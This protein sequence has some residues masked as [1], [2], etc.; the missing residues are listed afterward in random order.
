MT[1]LLGFALI[2]ER[3]RV[4]NPLLDLLPS[5]T[6]VVPAFNERPVIARTIDSLLASDVPI[7]VVIVDDGSTDGTAEAVQR[8]YRQDARVTLLRQT[9]AGKAAALCTGFFACRTEVVVALDGDTLFAPDTVRRLLEPMRDA[10]VA[11]VAGTA[12]VGNLENALTACQALEYFTQQELERRAWGLFSALPIVPG[13]VGAWRRHAVLDVG[14]F[15]SQTL[16]EDADLAMTLCRAGWRIAYSPLAHAHTEAPITLRALIQQRVRW[17]FGVLQAMWKHR[18]APFER[19]SGAFGRLVWP[20]MVLFQIVMPLLTPAALLSVTIAALTKNWQP[21]LCTAAV[22]LTVDYL[23]FSVAALLHRRA[24]GSG[25]W[26]FAGWV[27]G[28][29]LIYRPILLAVMLRSTLRVLDGLPL[30]W[31]KIRRRGTVLAIPLTRTNRKTK[32]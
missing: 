18:R 32:S 30:G 3:R 13:A 11:A 8:Q 7:E 26:R 16:A 14:G 31:G 2:A 21:A 29:R 6:A 17:T 22:L 10:R 1:L 28:A 25:G 5:V 24:G 9:N 15:S 27:L 20:A 4:A 12:E 23:Q 19:A